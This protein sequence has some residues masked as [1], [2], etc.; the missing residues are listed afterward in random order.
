MAS[1]VPTVKQVAWISLV[2]QLIVMGLIIYIFN[3]SQFEDPFLY[4]A[5]TYLGL[6][7]FLRNFIAKDHRE[8]MRLVK[9]ENF[10]EAIEKFER[11]VAF[12]AKNK[13]IDRY[14][15][16]TLLS[17]SKMTYKEM[18]LCNIAFCYSQTNQG[19]KAKAYYERA[20]KE[21]PKNGLAIAGLRMLKSIETAHK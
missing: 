17:S 1:N 6:S 16:L 13:W 12:F 4:G 5:L 3:L 21:F 8:G 20:L 14:R 18:G 19:E 2:P 9:K 15:F 7:F 10:Q 11:S